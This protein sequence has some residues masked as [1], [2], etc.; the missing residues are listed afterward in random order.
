MKKIIL[1][2]CILPLLGLTSC[3][4]QKSCDVCNGREQ[5]G[6]FQ[7]LSEPLSISISDTENIEVPALLYA[8]GSELA[9]YIIGNIP[10]KY[11][12]DNAIR[13]RVCLKVVEPTSPEYA[14]VF[15][16]LCIEDDE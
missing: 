12:T 5:V 7:Y 9:L 6:A 1:L 8:G 15:E 11:K 10:K 4:K 13:V 3:N 14:T 2:L 16:L